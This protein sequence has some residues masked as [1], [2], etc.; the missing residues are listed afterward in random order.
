MTNR[1]QRGA[2]AKGRSKAWLQS[3]GCVVFD[4]EIMRVVFTE[5]GTVPT[6]RD[7]LGADLGYLDMAKQVVVFVQVKGGLAPFATLFSQARRAF[8]QYRFPKHSRRELHIWRPGASA[9]EI[10]V[11][12]GSQTTDQRTARKHGRTLF[13]TQSGGRT[14]RPRGRH[15][16]EYLVGQSRGLT[17]R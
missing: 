17:Q 9:P 14:V 3:R 15:R 4:M 7:Q 12:S 8:G 6:K 2:Y 5:H 16:V 11:I 13:A 10:T 1:A